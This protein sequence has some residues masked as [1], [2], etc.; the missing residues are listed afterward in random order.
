MDQKTVKHG[1][2]RKFGKILYVIVYVVLIL[3]IAL[4]STMIFNKNYY[5][6]F[7]VDGQSMYPTLNRNGTR[8]I[9]APRKDFGIVDHHQSMIDKIKRFD[10]VTAYYRSD[11]GEDGSLRTDGE[12]NIIVEKKIK[13]IIGL[14]GE[15]IS[16]LQRAI[17][18]N[19][20]ELEITYTPGSGNLEV[21][22]PVILEADEYFLIGDNWGHSSDSTKA[23]VGAIKKEWINGVLIAIE[24]TC[25]LEYD[26]EGKKVA[27]DFKYSWPTFYKQ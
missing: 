25:L 20:S 15:T 6:T 21:S 16:T 2:M 11:Y 22:G 1:R 10:I 14:P 3:G 8:L 18:V 5:I 23:G 19:G 17:Y 13:R 7:Y 24:G 4:T 26:D 9:D 27:S 12:G